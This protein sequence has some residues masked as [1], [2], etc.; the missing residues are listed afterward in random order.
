MFNSIRALFRFRGTRV[1]TC[2]ETGRSEAVHV[3]AP[4]AAWTALT[5]RRPVLRLDA[6]TRWPERQDCPES[7]LRQIEAAPDTC[8]ARNMLHSWYAGKSCEFCRKPFGEIN[9][10]DHRP[11]LMS[12]AGVTREWNEISPRDLPEVMKTHVPVCWNCHIA[13]TFRR[14][15]PDL[16][17]DRDW[18]H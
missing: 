10:N 11:T 17:V 8:L 13:E 5:W 15:H 18:K 2:P 6:C 12:P 14:E 16:V 7:C 3:D 1:I 4:F 9:W